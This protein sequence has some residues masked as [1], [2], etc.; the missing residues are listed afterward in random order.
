MKVVEIRKGQ[1]TGGAGR[2]I[3]GG[4]EDIAINYVQSPEKEKSGYPK[5]SIVRWGPL[6]YSE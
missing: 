3:A 6:I 2:G 1:E 4:R 5:T